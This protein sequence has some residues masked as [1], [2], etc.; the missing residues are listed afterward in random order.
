MNPRLPDYLCAVPKFSRR[1]S[2]RPDEILDSAL[3]HFAAHGFAA[4]RMEEIAADAGVTAG[5]IYRYFPSKDS[6]VE[7]LVL[8]SA[9]PSWS[10][11]R[12]LADAYGSRTAREILQ[13][14]LT[15]WAEHLERPAAGQLLM[16][17][18][19]EAPQFPDVTAKYAKQLLDTGCL[20]LERALR[21]GIDRGEFPLLDIGATARSLA[22]TVVGHAVWRATFAAHLPVS[23]SRS[24]PGALALD[25]L[26]RGLPRPGEPEPG[27]TAPQLRAVTPD[28]APVDRGLRIV[29]LRPP[30]GTR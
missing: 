7:A 24:E 25:A 20:A 23:A 27:N 21:H 1:P 30:E 14:L 4:A 22:A 6:L 3:R 8:R 18:V 13:L 2:D 9:D 16:V 26:V 28:A 29:T 19:R 5:T 15:R 12:E 10:R 11:G 17:I